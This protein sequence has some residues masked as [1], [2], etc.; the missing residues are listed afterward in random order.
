MCH[1]TTPNQALV[2]SILAIK[3]GPVRVILKHIVEILFSVS[4]SGT[5]KSVKETS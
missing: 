3:T 4:E 1:K 2:I 5:K